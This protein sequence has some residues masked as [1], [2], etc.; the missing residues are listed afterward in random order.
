[1][2]GTDG[3]RNKVITPDKV[4]HSYWNDRGSM[5]LSPGAAASAAPGGDT[6]VHP[7]RRHALWVTEVPTGRM[8][9]GHWFRCAG[10]GSGTAL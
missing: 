5:P 8:G 7:I 6:S 4:D 3:R 9:Q 1:V 2:D 10:R